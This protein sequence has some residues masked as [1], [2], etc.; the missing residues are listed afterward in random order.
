MSDQRKKYTPAEK[1]KIALDAIKGELTLAQIS[2]KYGVHSSQ[3]NAWKKQLLAYLPDAFNDKSKQQTLGRVLN[4]KPLI[5]QICRFVN[6][7]CSSLHQP[8]ILL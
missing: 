3:I 7:F 4:L 6:F 8:S 1:A 5:E 2:S